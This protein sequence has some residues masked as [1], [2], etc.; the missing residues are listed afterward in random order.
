MTL[1]TESSR[2]AEMKSNA[3]IIVC[4]LLAACMSPPTRELANRQKNSNDNEIICKYERATGSHMSKRVCRSKRQIER[5]SDE[6]RD[7]LIKLPPPPGG[8]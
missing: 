8:E 5:E 6:I 4:L 7:V 1:E 2:I 3:I